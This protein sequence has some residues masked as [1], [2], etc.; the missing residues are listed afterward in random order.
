MFLRARKGNLYPGFKS[1]CRSA[2]TGENAEADEDLERCT[3]D[4]QDSFR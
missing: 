1:K 4:Q 3:F 2:V